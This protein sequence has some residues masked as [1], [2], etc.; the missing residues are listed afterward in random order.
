MKMFALFVSAAVTSLVVAA[1]A[2]A[3]ASHDM[4]TKSF[5][6]AASQSDEFEI[7]EGKLAAKKG[8]P[9]V[10]AFGEKMIDDHTK[11]TE[12][13]HAAIKQAGMAVPPPPPMTADQKDMAEKIDALSGKEF[14]RTYLKQQLVAHRK[15]LAFEEEYAKSG[16]TP[17]IK[18][19]A[20]KTVPIIKEHIRLAEKLE[21]DAHL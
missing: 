2:K 4:T 15:T 6:T 16:E 11:T 13:L 18:M 19:A 20:E 8:S 3:E 5:L 7:S 10:R 1:P 9:D 12:S 21:K 14:D 17:A